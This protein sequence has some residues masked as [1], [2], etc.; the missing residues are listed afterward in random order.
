MKTKLHGGETVTKIVDA[1]LMALKLLD[2]WPVIMLTT[3][4]DD[5]VVRWSRAIQ[6]RVEEVSCRYYHR[7]LKW[8]RSVFFYLIEVA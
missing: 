6:S 4:H 3:V 2:K 5:S 8:W 7:T 1:K